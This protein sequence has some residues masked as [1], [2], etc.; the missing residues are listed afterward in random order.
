M[1][2]GGGEGAGQCPGGRRGSH[3]HR[4][5]WRAG[6]WP[7]TEQE[8]EAQ[9]CSVASPGAHRSKC[10]DSGL[11]VSDSSRGE[12][13]CRAQAPSLEIPPEGGMTWGEGL[14]PGL[15]H[16]QGLPSLLFGHPLGLIFDLGP[17]HCLLVGSQSQEEV[18][19]GE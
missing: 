9:R 12:R 6:P 15:G 2:G 8:A 4:V 11:G 5:R 19:D 7:S 16:G 10:Q 14:G 18:A 17:G 3:D 13:N 1:A